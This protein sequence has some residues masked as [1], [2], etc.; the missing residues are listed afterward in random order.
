MVADTSN[1]LDIWDIL[2]NELVGDV[3]LFIF[4]GLI[5]IW[6]LAAKSKL[7]TEVSMLFVI[8]F[9]SAIFAKTGLTILWAF[10]ILGVGALFYYKISKI[11]RSG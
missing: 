11:I 2:V 10:T 1:F 9:L 4:L 6:F 7:T 5:M 3:W 8:L